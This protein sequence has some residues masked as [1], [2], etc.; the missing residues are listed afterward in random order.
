MKQ[1]ISWSI[2][3]AYVVLGSLVTELGAEELRFQTFT[4]QGVQRGTVRPWGHDTYRIESF[5][6]RGYQHKTVRPWG[7]DAYQIESHGQQGYQE[8]IIRVPEDK[9]WKYKPYHEQSREM[10]SYG[11][12]A[13]GDT[14]FEREMLDQGMW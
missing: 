1:L 8:T 7:H 11:G 10:R 14:Q 3:A 6:P 13:Y 2:I 12:D 4:P 9:P 5:G